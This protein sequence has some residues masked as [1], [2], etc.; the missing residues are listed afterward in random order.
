MTSD[1]AATLQ[2]DGAVVVRGLL[3]G[4]DA[5]TLKYIAE[6]VYDLFASCAVIPDA[7][8]EQNYRDWNGVWLCALPQFLDD[9]NRRLSVD[10]EAIVSRVVARVRDLFG[11]NWMP[12]PERSFFRRLTTKMLIPWHIDA[13]VA[14]IG[15]D[16]CINIW[17]PVDNVGDCLPSL[18]LMRGSHLTLRRSVG[19]SD[20]DQIAAG[21]GQPWAPRLVLGDALAFDQ[22][23]YH[24]T[25][26]MADE[27]A[28]RTSCEFRFYRA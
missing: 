25:Q 27:S 14:A 15:K 18:E 28:I 12:Y 3:N 11:E 21:L 2:R 4:S 24:R 9:R 8:L 7:D 16:H 1:T 26:P 19:K 13:D 10:F 20:C 17:M 6:A 23:T 5:A 22:Y